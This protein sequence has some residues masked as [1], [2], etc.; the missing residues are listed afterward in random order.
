MESVH[1]SKY[2]F[3]SHMKGSSNTIIVV[4]VLSIVY[5]TRRCSSFEASPMNNG[6]RPAAA[7]THSL[8]CRSPRG[9]QESHST[10][11]GSKMM[12]PPGLQ[13]YS[14][15]CV[16]LNFGLSVT[17]ELLRHSGYLRDYLCACQV[18]LKFD[19]Y[20]FKRLTLL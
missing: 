6:F 19:G 12:P 4:A 11:G 9:K 3:I 20:I 10:Q 2:N 14:R 8:R 7:M 16:T 1:F 13:V 17:S 15:P 5:P 18:W